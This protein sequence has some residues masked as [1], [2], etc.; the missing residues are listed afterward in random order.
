[1]PV[2]YI[3]QSA[4]TGKFYVGSAL[5]RDVRLAEHQRK[6]SPY[7]RSRGH[8]RLVYSEEYDTLAKAR[9]RE[10]QIKSWKVTSIHTRVDRHGEGWLERPG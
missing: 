10:R 4:T 2:M 1:M 5:D 7:T 8:W 3:L 6:H 9:R